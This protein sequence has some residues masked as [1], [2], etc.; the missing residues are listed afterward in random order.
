MYFPTLSIKSV[1]FVKGKKESERA[2][3]PISST[4]RIKWS[5]IRWQHTSFVWYIVC[6]SRRFI[7]VANHSRTSISNTSTACAGAYVQQQIAICAA[8]LILCLYSSTNLISS[9]LLSVLLL[10]CLPNGAGKWHD[11]QQSN[12][13]LT[14]SWRDC[15]DDRVETL[16]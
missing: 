14:T 12:G 6:L 7:S 11:H 10:L 1:L 2:Y 8:Y 9:R 16:E 15:Y 4:L 13:L 3:P 5:K